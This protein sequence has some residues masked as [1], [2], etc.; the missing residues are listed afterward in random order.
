M[1]G[2]LNGDENNRQIEM[3]GCGGKG[4]GGERRTER[5]SN[6]QEDLARVC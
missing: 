5:E 2:E 4:G 1:E 3:I 6:R